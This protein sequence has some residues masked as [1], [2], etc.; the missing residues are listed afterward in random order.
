MDRRQFLASTLGASLATLI[1]EG[2][3][4]GGGATSGGG[5]SLQSTRGAIK[6]PP[7]S[8]LTPAQLSAG[9]SLGMQT[10]PA[11]QPLQRARPYLRNP[12]IKPPEPSRHWT[13]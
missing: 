1:L 8:T 4:G 6:L 9:N 10:P 3:G 11:R 12:G 13:S 7:G 2:C 5:V